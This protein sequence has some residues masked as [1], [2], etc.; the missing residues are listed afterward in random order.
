[1][2]KNTKL[3]NFIFLALTAG[4]CL[5]SGC[6]SK[7]SNIED[8]IKPLKAM[9]LDYADQF[10]C[11]YYDGGY[12]HIHIADG[13]DYVL[14]PEGGEDNDLGILDAVII[15]MPVQDIYLAASS[16]MDLFVQ[17][18]SLDKIG[19]CSTTAD[20][21]SIEEA[22]A[23]IEDGTIKYV[24]KYSAPD[25]ESIINT[26]CNLTIESTMIT[27]SPE[28]K[29]EIEKLGIP[30]LVERSSYESSPMGRLEWIKLYGALLGK[31][32]EARGFFDGEK[33]KLEKISEELDDELTDTSD[34]PTVAFFYVSANGYV[35]VRKPGDYISTMIDMAGG[36]YCLNGMADETD[37]ALSTMNI[38]WESFYASAKEADIIIYNS[39]IDGGIKTVNDLLDKNELFAD[40]E[41]VKNGNVYC[42]NTDMFQK[43]SGIVDV[44]VD[45]FRVMNKKDEDKLTYIYKLEN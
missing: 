45:L 15:H 31:E 6:G 24:G 37:N 9:E 40:F 43:S 17:L 5:I 41:A 2:I 25:Y 36:E 22:K 39:T 10:S 34:K 1:M 21:Y 30:V 18:D 35:N 42:T 28:I 7:D 27:H 4:L 44:V 32:D 3:K 14:V 12:K 20:D 16:A 19:T 33:E 26:K 38:N 13:T 8:E 29:E 23:L 11:D